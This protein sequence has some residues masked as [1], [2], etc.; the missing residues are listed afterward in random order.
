V[1]PDAAGPPLSFRRRAA[2]GEA[3]AG[4]VKAPDSAPTVAGRWTIR[5]GW[6]ELRRHR[7]AAAAASRRRGRS[8]FLGFPGG[9]AGDFA[10]TSGVGKSRSSAGATG[11]S[12]RRPSMAAAPFGGAR[13]RASAPPAPA[14]SGR[15]GSELPARGQIRD[16]GVRPD[17]VSPR[18]ASSPRV[19]RLPAPCRSTWAARL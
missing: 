19:H 17:R 7:S 8:R 16:P 5:R 14:G 13:P 15:F 9:V 2:G 1:R 4:D 12:A 10:T 3:R 11:R 6:R 18:S